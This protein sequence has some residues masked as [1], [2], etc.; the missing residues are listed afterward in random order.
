MQGGIVSRIFFLLERLT[1]LERRKKSAVFFLSS[2]PDS[3]N[4]SIMHAFVCLSVCSHVDGGHDHTAAATAR[5][6]L[7]GAAA[8]CRLH[9]VVLKMGT[10]G[11]DD[12]LDGGATSVTRLDLNLEFSTSCSCNKRN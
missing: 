3:N 2:F 7:A 9:V 8:G 12:G 1:Y 11:S 6:G 4:E 5:A 10:V